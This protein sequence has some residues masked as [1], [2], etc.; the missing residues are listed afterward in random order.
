MLA[1]S[2]P[3]STLQWGHGDHAVE[4][5]TA[6]SGLSGWAS[7]QWG[8]GDHAVENAGQDAG[9]VGGVEASMGPRRSRRGEP[10]DGELL[11]NL[12]IRL[13][14]GHGDHAVENGQLEQLVRPAPG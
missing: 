13:Q 1:V 4:N 2:S 6:P 11:A 7:L 10:S 5:R 8:H 3:F 9:L 12:D 14:W